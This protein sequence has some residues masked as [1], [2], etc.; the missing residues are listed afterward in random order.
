MALNIK[1]TYQN[2]RKYRETYTELMRLSRR[3]LDDLGIHR[4]DIGKIAKQS[5]GY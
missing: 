3:E 2:W 1:A 4:A 5:A